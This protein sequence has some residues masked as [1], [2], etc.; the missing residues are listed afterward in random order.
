VK[1]TFLLMISCKDAPTAG[2]LESVLGPD[3]VDV[4]AGQRFSMR[5]RSKNLSFAI[6]SDSLRSPLASLQSV[7]A[8]VALFRE[9]WLISRTPKDWGSGGPGC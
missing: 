6:S 4:P 8:D 9:I 2:K 7:L 5:R 3:N 1:T